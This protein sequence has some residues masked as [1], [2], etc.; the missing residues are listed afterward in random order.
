MKQEADMLWS[1]CGRLPSLLIESCSSPRNYHS[2]TGDADVDN[3]DCCSSS[4]SVSADELQIG[5]QIGGGGFAIV[6]KALWH[7]TPVAVK[8]LF[9]PEQ[10]QEL[11]QE[12][13]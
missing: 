7:G 13:R 12:F 5:E 9:D 3:Y 11:V 6:S 2:K 10:N 1:R 8:Q 4:A